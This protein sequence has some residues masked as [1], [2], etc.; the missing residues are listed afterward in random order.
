MIRFTID[1]LHRHLRLATLCLLIVVG[2]ASVE[3]QEINEANT[4]F[5]LS[6]RVV[7]KTK[8]GFEVKTKQGDVVE[9]TASDS[10]DFALR[11]A[12]PWF[13]SEARRV[14]VDGKLTAN[15]TRERIR[16]SLPEG[17]L[18]LLA[19]FR[20]AAHR[21]RIMNESIWRINNY[22]ISDELI[23]PALPSGNEVFLAGEIDLAKP[24]VIVGDKSYPIVLGY[25]GATL[26]GRSIA[27]IVPQET[28]VVVSG[29]EKDGSK[30]ADTVL[31][32]SR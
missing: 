12:S 23:E 29:S 30:I 10:T 28:V 7:S 5:E 31:F 17:K 15:G 21:D 6:G 18:Y 11:M 16:Y 13:D 4:S 8:Y 24:A 3:A 14:V 19:Q 2:C 26:R 32:M 20:S 22:L 9:I 27:D 25:R 1:N